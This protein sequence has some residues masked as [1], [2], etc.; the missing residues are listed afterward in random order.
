MKKFVRSK[1]LSMKCVKKLL[2][3]V[4]GLGILVACQQEPGYRIIGSIPGTPDGM[5]VYLYDWNIPVDS[6]VV[7]DG[8]FVLTGKVEVPVRYQLWVDLSPDKDEDFEIYSCV[9]QI[10]A[11]RLLLSILWHLD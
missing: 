5:K 6:S 4:S 3:V 7:K 9:I 11:T 10:Y 2:Y 1:Y 8:K